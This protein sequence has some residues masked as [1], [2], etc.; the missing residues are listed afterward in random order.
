MTDIVFFF[1]LQFE[2]VLTLIIILQIKM[3]IVAIIMT[4]VA[5]ITIN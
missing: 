4:V 2:T 1:H 3:I 5:V